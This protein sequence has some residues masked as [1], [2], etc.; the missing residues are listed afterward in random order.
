LR[1][2]VLF[3]EAG[4]LRY[5]VETSAVVEVVPAVRVRPVPGAVR[6]VAGL[7][8]YRGRILPV[9][10]LGLLLLGAACPRRLSSRIVV[11]DRSGA[12]APFGQEVEDGRRLGLLAEHVT[13][14]GDLDPDAPGATRG[15]STPGAPPLGR[16]VATEGGMVQLVGVGDLVPAEVLA[17]LVREAAAG[18][19]P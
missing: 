2:Q 6:G 1:V 11:C 7:F 17:S 14:V 15:P 5:A 13:R 8:G 9:V 16:I 18:G 3:L 19:A 12:A 10:D 4:G